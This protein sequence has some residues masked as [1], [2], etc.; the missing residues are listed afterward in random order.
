MKEVIIYD[1]RTGSKFN[2]TNTEHLQIH[3]LIVGLM[4]GS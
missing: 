4:V 2:D 1:D 3:C